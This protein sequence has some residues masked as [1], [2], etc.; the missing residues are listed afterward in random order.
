MAVCAVSCSFDD[1][2]LDSRLDAVKARIEALQSRIDEAN[3]QVES[4][5]L[6][7]SGNVV[8][9][10]EKNSDGSY[11]LTYLDSKNE[12][13]TMVL[14]AMDQMINVP[15]IG[16]RKDENGLY[17]W[18][19]TTGGET[20]DITVDGKPVP[21]AGKT[22]VISVDE[23]GFWTV[24]GER[25]LNENGAPVEAKDGNSAIFKSIAMDADG[26]LSVTLGNGTALTIPVQNSLNLS[27]SSAL[28]LTI[29]NLGQV[30]KIGYSVTGSKAEGAIVAIAEAKSVTASL[31][32]TAKEV[33][34]SFGSTF[35]SGHL[36]LMATDLDKVTVLRPIFFDKAKETK[37]LISTAEDLMNFAKGV[38]A[39]DGT[40]NMEV[41]LEKDIDM[42]SVSN[43]TPYRKRNFLG[44]GGKRCCIQGY[45]LWQ[46]PHCQGIEDGRAC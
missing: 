31:D 43:W 35:E 10:V 21:A 38:N 18:T 24:D 2:G 33:S 16:V 15:V 6:L 12:S 17:Y 26:N 23:Q 9:S 13:K 14:A 28:N 30:L 45:F 19:V 44:H 32:K 29:S 11:V 41:Y 27:V 1:R 39:Q 36:I 40:E 34:V 5:G 3:G 7:T 8:T 25:I 42:S 22:P 4:L 20:T 37:I 46:E